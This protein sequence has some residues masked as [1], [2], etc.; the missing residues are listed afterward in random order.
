MEHSDPAPVI[1]LMLDRE[2]FKNA[3]FTGMKGRRT[4][5]PL[6]AILAIGKE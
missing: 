5:A 4:G 3:D 6:D 2:S 1:D